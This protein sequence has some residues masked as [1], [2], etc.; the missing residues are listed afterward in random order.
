MPLHIFLGDEMLLYF[1]V[2]VEVIEIQI[3]FEFKLVYNLQ[4][5]LKIKREF[6]NFLDQ[7]GPNP[8]LGP[9]SLLPRAA[10]T[11]QLASVGGPTSLDQYHHIPIQ[12][13]IVTRLGSH[14]ARGAVVPHT[15][16]GNL[17]IAT[18]PHTIL[19]K[20]HMRLIVNLCNDI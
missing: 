16:Q 19:A 4:K 5:G 15:T 14:G 11:S 6:S 7:F 20:P 8:S 9:A 12:I 17:S 10:R 18:V 1:I 3:W 13:G 2:R